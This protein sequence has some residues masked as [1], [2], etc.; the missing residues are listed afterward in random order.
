MQGPLDGIAVLDLS[1]GAAGPL[2][3]TLLGDLGADVIK[4]E[5]PGGEWGRQ[6]GPPFVNGVA[7]AFLGLNR[8]KRSLVID[9]KREGATDV[10]LRLADRSDVVIESFRPG[11]ADRL[12]IGW[13]TMNERNPRLVYAGISAYGLDGPWRD[14]PGVDGVVQAMSGIMSVTGSPD[15]PPVKVGVPAADM[16]GGAFTTQAVLAGLYAR[17]R[18]GRGQRVDV[19]LLDALL[20][21][22]VVP[23]T[24]FLASGTPPGRL[25]SA[26]P[27]AAP[28]EAFPT[29]DGHVMVAA[30]TPQRWARFCDAIGHPELAVDDRFATNAD[31]VTHRDEF[32]RVVDPV[33]AARTTREWIQAF[34]DADLM[35]GPLYD[36]PGLVA[37]DHLKE[38]GSIIDVTHPSVG[39]AR[40]VGSPVRM[41]MTPERPIGQSPPLLGEHSVEV[42][43]DH[44]FGEAEVTDLLARAVVHG[45]NDTEGA[46]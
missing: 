12:G 36:Y 30:Y 10:V 8:N 28:N 9:L 38:R 4:V 6:L 27:Y 13:E 25:G 29:S 19:A 11:V 20:M 24:M 33:L 39:T 16:A 42:L 37:E 15:G 44:G 26:A 3:G 1:Q 7:A 35:C 23:L 21:F 17:E 18:T 45:P 40:T 22:Q 32:H 41:S 43:M 46:P 31:R 5:P 14:R 2:C 34:D